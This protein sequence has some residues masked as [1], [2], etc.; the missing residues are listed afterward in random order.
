MAAVSLV[1]IGLFTRLL[2]SSAKNTDLT[3]ANLLARS[4]LDRAARIG[5]P[6]WGIGSE[7]SVS[8]G[9]ASL[10]TNGDESKTDFSY[11]IDVRKATSEVGTLG[12]LYHLTVTVSWWGE[13]VSSTRMRQGIGKV[14]TQL[15]RTVYI[16][17]ESP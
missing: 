2:A 14:S 8:G 10:Q 5:P 15:T 1:V 17:E 4:I 9:T 6:K 3:T 11:E 12:Q 7:H 13:D 16:R